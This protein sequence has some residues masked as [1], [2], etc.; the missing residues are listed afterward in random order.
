MFCL[1]VIKICVYSSEYLFIEKSKSK[2]ENSSLFDHQFNNCIA[3]CQHPVSAL[4]IIGLKYRESPLIKTNLQRNFGVIR[5]I[6]KIY[7]INLA[8][9]LT[10]AQRPFKTITHLNLTLTGCNVQCRV[11]YIRHCDGYLCQCQ[12]G[13]LHPRTMQFVTIHINQL[14]NHDLA[15]LLFLSYLPV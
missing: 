10:L 4:Y 8:L 6:A 9:F 7:L 3:Q 1:S 12:G 5:V 11:D 15:I 14:I 2:Q 13:I